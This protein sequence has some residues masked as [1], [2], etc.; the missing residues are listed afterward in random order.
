[1]RH[2][3]KARAWLNLFSDAGNAVKA[4]FAQLFGADEP[5]LTN[6]IRWYHEAVSQLCKIFGS[7]RTTIIARAPGRVNLVGMHV[8]HRGGHVNPIAAKD[9]IMVAEPRDDDRVVLHN[10]DSRFEPCDFSILEES[11]A[12]PV[13][14]WDAWTRARYQERVQAG[15]AS[16]WSNYVKAP[17]I[18]LQNQFPDRNLRGMNV[19]VS[20]TVPQAAGMSSSSA[21]VVCA[22]E[23]FVH[24]NQLSFSDKALVELCSAAEWYIGTRGGAGDHAAIKFS[25]QGCLSQIGFYPLDVTLTPFP[26][27]YQVVVCNTGVEARKAAGARDAFN[28]RVAAY[29][30]G[31]MLIKHHFPAFEHQLHH[32]RDVSATNLGVD[33]TQIYRMLMSLPEVVSRPELFELLPD[34]RDGL[35]QVFGT[36]AAPQNG[37]FVRSVCLYGLAECERSRLATDRLKKG[38]V[39]GF[40]DLMSLS[41]EG[42]R[43]SDFRNGKSTMRG[44][45]DC[46]ALLRSLIDSLESRV[47]VRVD[48]AQLYRQP[49]GYGVSCLEGDALVDI[50]LGIEGVAGARLTGAGLGGC[51]AVL[52]ASDQIDRVIAAVTNEFYEPRH[53]P[54]AIEI[55]TPVAGSGVLMI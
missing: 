54:T 41:H 18:Y 21:M 55:C 26:A 32:L 8:D 5:D 47:A 30:I 43:V 1:M 20:G 51:V 37:Y 52:V 22:A 48:A 12:V 36:H 50:A 46:G 14:D 24:L 13:R 9:L 40:G 7:D 25:R 42:D 49:G 27:G 44:R 53:M 11:P 4:Q 34:H 10:T 23:A 39:T 33:E 38:D 17:L 31:L 19:L 45:T 2:S 3:R 35:A 16:H 15:T 29:D 28:Q 6:H